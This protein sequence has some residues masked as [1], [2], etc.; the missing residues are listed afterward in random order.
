ML[1]LFK[2]Q[3]FDDAIKNSLDA[4]E[5]WTRKKEEALNSEP[6]KD[7]NLNNDNDEKKIGDETEKDI[8]FDNDKINSSSDDNEYNYYDND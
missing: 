3:A 6:E 8:P 4:V 7:N 1:A 2:P 5:Y